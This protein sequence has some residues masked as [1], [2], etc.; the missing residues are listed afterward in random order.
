MKNFKLTQ[1]F[2]SHQ[3][4]NENLISRQLPV[5]F[6]SPQYVCIVVLQHKGEWMRQARI[7]H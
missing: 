6:A 1:D 2:A 5:Q 3:N 4:E 7:Y